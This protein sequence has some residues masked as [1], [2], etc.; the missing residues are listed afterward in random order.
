M[1]KK[2][3]TLTGL[4]LLLVFL[5]PLGSGQAQTQ[6]PPSE[7]EIAA[8]LNEHPLV[9]DADAEVL[10]VRYVGEALVIDLSESVLPD[11]AYDEALFA[12]LQADLDATFGINQ[13]FMTT[14]KVEG[15]V[16]EEWGRPIPDFSET[17]EPPSPDRALLGEGPLM[18]YKIALSPGHGLYWSETYSQWTYQRAEFWGIRE[19][20]VNSEIMRYLQIILL[21]QGATVIQLRE[22]DPEAR[23]GVSGYPAWYEDARQYAIHLGLPDSIWDGSNNNYNSDIRTRPYMA[24]YY[25]A[26]VLI[27]FHNN[28][29]NGEL[30]GT[31]TYYDSNNDPGSPSLA[32]AVHNSII[33]TMT[34]NYGYW[35]NRGVKM[36]NDDYGEIN[37]A[38]MPAALVE[39]AFMDNYYDNQLL[40]RESFKLLAAEAIADGICDFLGVTCSGINTQLEVPSLSPTYGDG[41]CDSGWYQY[42]NDRGYNAYLTLNTNGTAA[43]TATWTPTLSTS[44]EYLVEAYIPDHN[45]INWSCPA[46][47][48]EHD[49][50]YAIYTINHANGIKTTYLNQAASAGTW[51][52]LG[53]FHFDDD[54]TS[55]VSLYDVTGES[56]GTTTVSASAVRFTLVGNAGVP[57]YNTEWLPETW[58]NDRVDVPVSDVRAFME[59]HRS[60]L[61]DPIPDVDDE[62]IDV[63]TLIQQASSTNQISPKLL[64]AVMEAEQNALTTCP[65]DTALA[66]LMGLSPSSTA[67]AQIADA[68]T[69]LGTALA[70]LN[71]N[72]I[73][74]NDWQAGVANE[75]EDGVSVTPAN[76]SIALLFDYFQNAGETWGGS[77]P[78]ETGVWGA[79]IAYRDYLLRLPL[80]KDVYYRFLP[81][82]LR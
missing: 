21:N 80:P 56:A 49:T 16:L 2:I 53:T 68:G 5:L 73:T 69:R 11:G 22:M 6:H 59:L 47:T 82:I 70:E 58:S 63:P 48:I 35:T 79:Y 50:G 24:N 78:G 75:T 36:S 45:T 32:N 38:N 1:K 3:L 12:Q 19:D 18:G 43:N 52:T 40:H 34:A 27:S 44:G 61:E 77:T 46:T 13:Q 42:T 28:G 71:T 66:N 74:P 60:C 37:Y 54:T 30:R 62:L 72:G 67:R 31:E 39:L 41:M 57:F 10:S 9:T 51:A 14:F 4:T 23:I 26:D 20:I 64:L 15:L 81:V 65:D 7:A 76:D 17:V 55:S 29:W 25:G 8:F 33:S